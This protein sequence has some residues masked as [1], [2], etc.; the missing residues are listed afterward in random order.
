VLFHASFTDPDDDTETYLGRV[1]AGPGGVLS[2]TAAE[3]ANEPALRRFVEELNGKEELRVKVPPTADD[4][5]FALVGRTYSRSRPDFLDGLRRYAEM[6]YG[7]RLRTD[8]DVRRELAER[9]DL[10]L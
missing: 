4:E 10:T 2:V 1:T 7:I 5:R 3:P 6:N 9:A 8:A